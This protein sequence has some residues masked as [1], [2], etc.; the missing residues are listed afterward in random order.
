MIGSSKHV[1]RR[2]SQVARPDSVDISSGIG[3]GAL[4][5]STMRTIPEGANNAMPRR[6]QLCHWLR[7]VYLLYESEPSAASPEEPDTLRGVNLARELQLDA[8]GRAAG[9]GA[10]ELIHRFE[11]AE[12]ARFDCELRP[13][14]ELAR[15]AGV[16]VRDFVSGTCQPSVALA[17]HSEVLPS[18]DPSQRPQSLPRGHGLRTGGDPR[19]VLEAAAARARC[20]ARRPAPTV[21][22]CHGHMRWTRTQLESELLHGAWGLN[23][24]GVGSELLD[25][26]LSYET[27][28]SEAAGT[29]YLEPPPRPFA[30]FAGRRGQAS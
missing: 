20:G 25:A 24:E 10:S 9:V 6:L 8:T 17:I 21:L 28:V 27:L 3:V 15:A 7:A 18:A 14:V 29:R 30:G 5:I 23:A 1:P 13:H 2:P 19:A 22:L 26:S 4:L 16:V 11:L 12:S